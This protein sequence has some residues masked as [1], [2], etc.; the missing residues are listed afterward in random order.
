[1]V[2]SRLP[3]A[4]PERP[5]QRPRNALHRVSERIGSVM[6][7]PMM[8][9]NALNEAFAS[10]TN[11]IS[12]ALPSFPAATLGSMAVGLPH[13]HTLHPPSG[14]PPIP[15]TPL[16]SIGLV[17]LGNSVQVLINNK[18]AARSGDLGFCPTCVGLPPIFEIVTGSSKVFIAGS[19]AARAIDITAH[20]KCNPGAGAGRAGAAAARSAAQIAM[21]AG[22]V[23][24]QAAGMV[25]QGASIAGDAVAADASA[26]AGNADMAAAMGLSASMGAAQ[27]A[28]DAVAMAVGMAMGLDVCVPP[29]TYGA[30]V[31]GSPNVQ[32]GGF[33]MP[34]W[35]AIAK[36]LMKLVR[37]LRARAAGRGGRGRGGVSHRS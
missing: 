36:G 35:M 14:P 16:P 12:Q 6:A 28:A 34:S 2:M 19:R 33:P 21:T 29:G 15:P 4:Q 22:M 23:G 7:V 31:T 20:C 13:A 25:A 26:E 32:I 8:P 3:P 5:P 17:A 1:M 24:V 11:A 27:M 37:G 18:P 10:A 30:I 9:V